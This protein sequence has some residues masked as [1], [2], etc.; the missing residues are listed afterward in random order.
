M[1]TLGMLAR[2]RFPANAVLIFVLAFILVSDILS[3]TEA[4]VGSSDKGIM[5]IAV[6]YYGSCR[7][8]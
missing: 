6:L 5:T 1:V 2:N 4:L 8:T 7:F 3:P